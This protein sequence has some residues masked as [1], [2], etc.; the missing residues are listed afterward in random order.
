M[1]GIKG[2]EGATLS[3]DRVLQLCVQKIIR[4]VLSYASQHFSR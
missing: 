3:R 4:S 1:S 2:K